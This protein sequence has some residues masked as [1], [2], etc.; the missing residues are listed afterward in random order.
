[1]DW[2]TSCNR[3]V[4]GFEIVRSCLHNHAVLA[5]EV[6][7]QRLQKFPKNSEGIALWKVAM[8]ALQLAVDPKAYGLVLFQYI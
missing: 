3:E 4:S 8:H 6:F 1:M 7:Q 5:S 2:I